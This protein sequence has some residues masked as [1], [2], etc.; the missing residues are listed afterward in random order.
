MDGGVV[1]QTARRYK[2]YHGRGIFTASRLLPSISRSRGGFQATFPL[3]LMNRHKQTDAPEKP[4]QKANL[5]QE[6]TYAN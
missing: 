3:Y 4:K 5:K 6:K 2:F 1:I